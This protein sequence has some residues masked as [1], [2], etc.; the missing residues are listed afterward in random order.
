MKNIN[1][2]IRHSGA[3]RNPDNRMIPRNAGRYFGVVRYAE[4]FFCWIP[5]CAGMTEAMTVPRNRT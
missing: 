2:P 3:G 4:Y 1:F 5:A